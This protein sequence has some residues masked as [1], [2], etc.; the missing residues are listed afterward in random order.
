MPTSSNFE[1]TESHVAHSLKE[2]PDSTKAFTKELHGLQQS[3]S[4]G[5]FKSDMSKLNDDLH[6]QGLLPGM[7]IVE[8]E[9]T[10]EFEIKKM[11]D[12][13][14]QAAPEAAPP[15]S[16]GDQPAAH[17]HPGHSGGHG[18]H[19]GGGGH[20]AEHHGKHHRHHKHHG[21]QKG[22]DG[23]DNDDPSDA[24]DDK[25][26]DGKKDSAPG[27][28]GSDGTPDKSKAGK[29]NG[30]DVAKDGSNMSKDEKEKYIYNRLTD[31]SEGGLHLTKAQ[32]AG[33]IG[34]LESE[35]KNL[36]SGYTDHTKPVVEHDL[37]FANWT[38]DR[39]KGLEDFAKSQGKSPTDFKTQV[40]WM[41]DELKTKEH[42]TV[43]QDALGDL[44]KTDS[45]AAAA[46]V[47]SKEFE[48][49]MAQYAHN[50]DR[51][52][53]AQLAFANMG[54]WDNQFNDDVSSLNAAV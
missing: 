28:S 29:G 37:G 8:N 43:K 16:T 35:S 19:H 51:I 42:G 14:S 41:I 7:Q 33:V 25:S 17:G 40:D 36:Y 49:P 34:N 27:P 47:F 1:R 18:G 23:A 38:K 2:Q 45:V 21:G 5:Q 15:T 52:N 13:K 12:A 3:E 9:K 39:K 26:G 6:K 46:K 4:A 10:G 32:A 31:K 44:R 54:R 53:N 20:G 22:G 48:R 24:P 30:S 11:A 50:Q